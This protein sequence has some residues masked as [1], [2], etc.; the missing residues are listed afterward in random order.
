MERR[1]EGDDDA[2]KRTRK[3]NGNGKEIGIEEQQERV[4]I[5]LMME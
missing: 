4:R 5:G 1:D 2:G 3:R